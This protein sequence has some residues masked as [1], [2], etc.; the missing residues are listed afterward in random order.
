LDDDETCGVC[1]FGPG[2]I[3]LGRGD[4]DAIN[5]LGSWLTVDEMLVFIFCIVHH[6]VVSSRKDDF[7]GVRVLKN[8][9]FEISSVT[10]D[11]F[12]LHDFLQGVRAHLFN[13]LYF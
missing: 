9:V 11:V 4:I 2:E 7:V 3:A 6:D 10:E 12:H 1:L 5:A 8:V 13:K